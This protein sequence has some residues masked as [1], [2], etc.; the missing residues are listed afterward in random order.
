M[1]VIINKLVFDELMK[2]MGVA[3]ARLI[4]KQS[5]VVN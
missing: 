5:L 3:K 1:V 2:V 4:K